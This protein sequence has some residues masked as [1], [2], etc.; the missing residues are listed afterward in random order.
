MRRLE[1]MFELYD[2]MR[3]DHFLGFSSY[4][5]VPQGKSAKEGSWNFGPGMK[6]FRKAY[7]KFGP[8]PV[9][10]EDLGIVTPAVRAL[11]AS[12]GFPGMDVI[13][14]KDNDVREK[15]ESAPGKMAYSGT[16]D[17]QTLLGW[18]EQHFFG[19]DPMQAREDDRARWL[20]E[21]LLRKTLAARATVAMLPLQDVL[22]LDDRDRMNVPG[23][24]EGNWSWQAT[25]EQLEASRDRL[26]TLA[27]ES[28]RKV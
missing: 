14:F 17:T 3:L 5:T 4:Y 26:R 2:Y 15:Y 19:G 23:V 7:A 12:T 24:S 11:V 13:Q 25:S 21:D 18:C 27:E 8:L 28:G 1:R 9:I 20:A 22:G 6:L 10:A 16:H